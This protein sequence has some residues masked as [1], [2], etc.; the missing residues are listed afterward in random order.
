[1]PGGSI[2]HDDNGRYGTLFLP[3]SLFGISRTLRP[4]GKNCPLQSMLGKGQGVY[5]NDNDS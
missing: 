5:N 1:M 3:T 4:W 2:V